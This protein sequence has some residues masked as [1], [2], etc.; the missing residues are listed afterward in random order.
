M[1][2]PHAREVLTEPVSTDADVLARVAAI[3]GAQARELRTLWLFFI[4]PDGMQSNAVVPIDPLPDAPDPELVGNVCHIVSEVLSGTLP[5]GQ[6]VV[7][8]SRPGAAGPTEGD[9]SW[10]RALREGTTRHET[11]VRMLCLVTP[12]GVSE[13]GPVLP[14]RENAGARA[15]KVP[16]PATGG[17]SRGTSTGR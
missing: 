13:L 10:L 11:P 6:A 5:G 1:N 7:T 15:A 9:L 8:L 16:G 14:A 2:D 4:G 12:A 17:R 3:V